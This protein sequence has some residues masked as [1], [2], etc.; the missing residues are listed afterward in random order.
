MDYTRWLYSLDFCTPRYIVRRELGKE[1]LKIRWGIRARKFEEKI[2]EMEEERWVKICWEEKGNGNWKDAYSKERERY[3]NRNRW[4]VEA[5]DR[6]VEENRG[7]EM[8]LMDRDR[9][10]DW[11]IDEERIRNAKYNKK[12]KEMRGDGERPKYLR[13][14]FLEN[15]KW[16][17]RIRALAKI[18]CGNMEED[19]KY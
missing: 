17:E 16:G 1:K 5:I 13:K 7:F 14:K 6:L 4:G 15:T 2:K 9:K 19:N 10:V 18:R 8:E 11:Q 3:Y 12:Y